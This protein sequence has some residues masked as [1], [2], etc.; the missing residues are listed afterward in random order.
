MTITR[1][2]RPFLRRLG[3]LA[4]CLAAAGSRSAAAQG[5]PHIWPERPVTVTYDFQST[6]TG[7][8]PLR[9]TADPMLQV[10]RLDFGSAG[11]YLLLD[12]G[13][14]QV[15]LVS[16]QKGMVF[17]VASQGF[18]HRDLGPGSNLA[19]EPEGR[20]MIAG[21]PC[22]EW[23]VTGPDGVGDACVTRDGVILEGQGHGTKPDAQGQVQAGR[24]IATQISDAAVSP[25][26][27]APPPGLQEVTLPLALF[28]AMVPGLS[29]L[30]AP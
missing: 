18:L 8:M 25:A 15:R 16:P 14:E 21:W 7:P 13:Q 29:G 24:L 10:L 19:F 22:T 20:R 11:D 6:A 4:L 23:K 12:R 2:R 28:R 1:Y 3:L 30:P 5:Y 27:F 26:V 17:V 9:L